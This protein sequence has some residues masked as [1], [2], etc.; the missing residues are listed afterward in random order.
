MHLK[1]FSLNKVAIMAALFFIYILSC[2]VVNTQIEQVRNYKLIVNYPFVKDSG[3]L[4]LLGDTIPIAYYKNYI[5]YSMPYTYGNIVDG[6]MTNGEKRYTHFVFRQGEKTGVYFNNRS[7]TMKSSLVGVDTFLLAHGYAT[8]FKTDSLKLVESMRLDK[9]DSVLEKY[10]IPNKHNE[11]EFDSLYCYFSKS[12]KNIDYSLSKSLDSIRATKLYKVRLMYDDLIS[13]TQHIHV[14]KREFV[15][16]IV[17]D[18]INNDADTKNWINLFDL[19]SK[20]N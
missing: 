10:I 7:G 17:R 18:T 16:K 19:H 11:F 3:Q 1:I 12:M 8:D 9:G 13:P 5:V 6:V 4:I 20:T 14:P 15:F 2:S